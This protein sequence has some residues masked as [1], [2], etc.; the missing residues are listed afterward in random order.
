M[1]QQP[2]VSIVIPTYNGAA[3]LR[4]CVQSALA[5]TERDIEI[6]IVDDA[7]SDNTARVAE[8]IARRDP[9]VRVVI[10]ERN[11]GLVGNWN[12]AIRHARGDWVKFLFQDDLLAPSCVER[13]VA[14]A[15]ATDA[16]FVSCARDFVFENDPPAHDQHRYDENRELVATLARGG[17]M[18]PTDVAEF[19]IHNVGINFVGEPTVTLLRRSVFDRMGFFDVSLAQRCD[20]EF[21]VRVGLHEGVTFVQDTLATFRVHGA[22]ASAANYARRQFA[23]QLLDPIIILHHYLF[24]IAYAPLRRVAGRAGSMG[25]LTRRFWNACAD[26]ARAMNASSG[27]SD[28]TLKDEWQRVLVGYPR[29]AMIPATRRMAWLG[30]RCA[31]ALRRTL[32]P[33]RANW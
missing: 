12:N 6:L 33:A 17:R 23:D 21:W 15:V 16:A 24:D 28:T 31:R 26:A 30:R 22:S 18:L 5:Q 4:E 2:H 20:T 8:T 13:L 11:L 32:R 14:A 25:R 9:R 27:D 3:F 1:P 7:S 19:A 10:N 29:L